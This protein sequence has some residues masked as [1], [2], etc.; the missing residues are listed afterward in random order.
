MDDSTRAAYYGD[1]EIKEALT[2]ITERREETASAAVRERFAHTGDMIG[3]AATLDMSTVYR[4]RETTDVLRERDTV[5][6]LP[7]RGPVAGSW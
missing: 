5:D 3:R 1:A 6:T 7:V 2:E 4:S